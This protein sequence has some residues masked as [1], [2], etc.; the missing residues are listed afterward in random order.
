MRFLGAYARQLLLTLL[1]V[2]TVVWLLESLAN[3]LFWL[4]APLILLLWWLLLRWEGRS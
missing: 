4:G 1:A 3:P 2:G